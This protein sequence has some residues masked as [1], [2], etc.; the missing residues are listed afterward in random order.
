MI[1]SESFIYVPP[2]W[3]QS[4]TTT[5]AKGCGRCLSVQSHIEECEFWP[6]I[7]RHIGRLGL[8][9]FQVVGTDVNMPVSNQ[10]YDISGNK[11][12]SM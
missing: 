10:Y 9:A 7:Y 8:A 2:M 12:K 4:V 6:I 11:K 5:R 1:P 3:L